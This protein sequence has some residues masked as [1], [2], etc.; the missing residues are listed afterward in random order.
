MELR[1]AL[2]LFRLTGRV[3]MEELNS[4]FRELVKKYHPD[5]VR[6]HPE[7]AHERMAEIND[8]YESLAEWI[9]TPAE[10]AQKK[11]PVKD[12]PAA[13]KRQSR[14]QEPEYDLFR[15]EIPPLNPRLAEMF[16]P[17]FNGFL[18]GLG[19]YYQYGLENSSYRE[20]GV[21]R[22]RYREAMRVVEKHRNMLEQLASRETHPAI[23][24]AA[25]FA[26]LSTADMN[27]G[28]PV[29][30]PGRP[31][32]KQFDRRLHSA[33]RNF[34]SAVRAIFFPELVPAHRRG[35]TA[36]TLYSSYTEFILYVTI[37]TE[38][39]RRKAGILQAA[40]YDAFMDLVEYRNNSILQF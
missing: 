25:R 29:F 28:D 23:K 20:E 17:V 24:T 3:P 38:G 15:R 35:Q 11:A 40:R 34:D 9:A 14:P 1:K 26:K 16:Y 12:P 7:W 33:R 4:T 39:E 21:R 36:A 8:A 10:P 13:A 27:I 6:D 37:F 30:P 18:D 31:E 22:F 32:W 19:L 2:T 5:K